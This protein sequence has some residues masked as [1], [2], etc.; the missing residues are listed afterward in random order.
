[1]R[2]R[3][4][5]VILGIG[6][7]AFEKVYGDPGGVGSGHCPNMIYIWKKQLSKNAD[8]ALLVTESPSIRNCGS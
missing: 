1:M 6:S 5:Q 8:N 7:P 3:R 4:K 2:K